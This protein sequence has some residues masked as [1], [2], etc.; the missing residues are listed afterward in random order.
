PA[1]ENGGGLWAGMWQAPTLEI[2][3]EG[4][5]PGRERVEAWLGAGS[6]AAGARFEFLAT[7]RRLR[8][9]VWRAG[10]LEAG[11]AR[12]LVGRAGARGGGGGGGRGGGGGGRGAGGSRFGRRSGLG[13]LAMSSP[14]R[15]LLG[16]V[17]AP[18]RRPEKA[19]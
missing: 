19:L 18:P 4:R 7:H 3:G 16:V 11:V 12:L 5:A 10:R 8:F 9:Q 2:G 1:T 13:G 17:S 15:R 14:Q 6:L